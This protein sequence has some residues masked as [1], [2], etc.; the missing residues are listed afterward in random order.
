ML[1]R[2]RRRFVEYIAAY[3]SPSNPRPTQTQCRS[4]ALPSVWPDARHSVNTCDVVVT[5]SLHLNS[6]EDGDGLD[7]APTA[8]AR[9]I[10]IDIDMLIRM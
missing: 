5:E 2:A 8:D 9:S 3:L 1:S 10:D 4:C 6:D 7:I